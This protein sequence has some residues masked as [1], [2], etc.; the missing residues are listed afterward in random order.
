MDDAAVNWRTGSFHGS[1][2]RQRSGAT[3]SPLASPDHR[4]SVYDNVP[5]ERRLP[6][7]GGGSDAKHTSQESEVGL[8]FCSHF[9]AK[10]GTSSPPSRLTTRAEDVALVTSLLRGFIMIQWK[11]TKSS[12][13]P[14]KRSFTLQFSQSDVSIILTAAWTSYFS[15]ISSILFKSSNCSIALLK[16]LAL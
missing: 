4:M 12:F 11:E 13:S 5:D 10:C 16:S 8:N 3:R 6:C 15:F 9:I 1:C 14:N 2:Q 7:G